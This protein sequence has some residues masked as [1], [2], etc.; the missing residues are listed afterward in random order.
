MRTEA[1]TSLAFREHRFSV[2]R[3]DGRL[4]L[5]LQSQRI[6]N[7]RGFLPDSFA[8]SRLT[9]R[10]NKRNVVH[11]RGLRPSSIW[12]K[13]NW[14]CR[15]LPSCCGR[16]FL[17]ETSQTRF[18]FSNFEKIWAPSELNE[19]NVTVAV[20][21]FKTVNSSVINC[22]TNEQDPGVAPGSSAFGKPNCPR[23]PSAAG[24]STGFDKHPRSKEGFNPRPADGAKVSE[25]MSKTDKSLTQVFREPLPLRCIRDG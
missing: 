4:C 17:V 16:C 7:H 20:W 1:H 2:L 14:H 13:A 12:R 6:E 18:S 3:C 8:G 23:T 24:E 10:I 22:V 21:P 11:L 9:F 5:P 19:T 25:R 15:W